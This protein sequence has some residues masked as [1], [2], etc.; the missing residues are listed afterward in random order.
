MTIERADDGGYTSVV[1]KSNSIVALAFSIDVGLIT[2]ANG[3]AEASF[4]DEARFAEASVAVA[5][6]IVSR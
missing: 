5:V 1:V 6:I 4:F 3:V 2:R